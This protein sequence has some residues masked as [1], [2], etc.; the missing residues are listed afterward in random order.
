MLLTVCCGSQFNI[1]H[2]QGAETG[3]TPETEVLAQNIMQAM[4]V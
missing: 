2:V 4:T 1:G 3:I